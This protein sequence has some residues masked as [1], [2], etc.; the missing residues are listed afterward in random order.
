MLHVLVSVMSVDKYHSRLVRDVTFYLPLI[1]KLQR[2]YASKAIAE[3]MTWHAN[4][5]TKEGLMCHPSDVEAW[6]HFDRTYPQ[7]AIEP[8]NIRLG[9]CDDGFAPF[10]KSGKSYSCWPVILMPYNLPPGMC[11]KTLYMFLT[12]IVTGLQ[13]LKKLIDVCMQPLI[14]ELQRLWDEGILTYDV[15]T[16]QI[17]VMKAAL[18]WTINDFSAYGMLF[19]WSTTGILRCPICLER[20]KSFRLK[21]WEE[22]Q[23]F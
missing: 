4:N 10:G 19:E 6:K 21:T 17:F 15:S 16:N 2:L 8:Q 11:M 12:L 9:L 5:E 7:F 20:S 23:L 13:N 22:A 18:L 14:E 1:P 3:H